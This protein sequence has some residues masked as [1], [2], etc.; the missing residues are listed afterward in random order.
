MLDRRVLDQP[1]SFCIGST[2]TENVN[3]CVGPDMM[4]PTPETATMTHP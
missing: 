4:K 1:R 2:N 3:V